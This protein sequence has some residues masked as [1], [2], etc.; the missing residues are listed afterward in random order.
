[1]Q[2][3]ENFINYVENHLPACIVIVAGLRVLTYFIEVVRRCVK[4]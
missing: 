1:M 4:K 3:L 2:K